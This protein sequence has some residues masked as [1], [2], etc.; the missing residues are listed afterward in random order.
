M[1][2]NVIS[3]PPICPEGIYD[4]ETFPAKKAPT[5]VGDTIIDT[6]NSPGILEI[7]L[8]HNNYHGSN[9]FL[10][11][12]KNSSQIHTSFP[13]ETTDLIPCEGSNLNQ[14]FISITGGPGYDSLTIEGLND[15]LP[16]IVEI[17]PN[18]YGPEDP[19]YFTTP[20]N[21]DNP[22]KLWAPLKT[23]RT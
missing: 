18:N 20:D 12:N 22:F 1:E 23:Q 3:F 7:N 4:I 8:N 2:P 13:N 10:Y 6:N 17:T 14:K 21:E 9:V 19:R 11:L 16:E 5:I 15:W